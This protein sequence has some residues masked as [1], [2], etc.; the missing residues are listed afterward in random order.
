M[1]NNLKVNDF[2][3]DKEIEDK[4]KGQIINIVPNQNRSKEFVYV[5]K[6]NDAIRNYASNFKV[7]N[8]KNL[9]KV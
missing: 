8:V 3:I 6:F 5:V 2:V 1:E 7:N 9:I 4:G